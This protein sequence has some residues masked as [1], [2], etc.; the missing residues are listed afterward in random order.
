MF[1]VEE[2]DEE[3]KIY[4]QQTPTDNQRLPVNSSSSTIHSNKHRRRM[5]KS[6][7]YSRQY[8]PPP[9]FQKENDFYPQGV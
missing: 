2:P 1:V 6:P 3:P 7:S 4:E 9:R 8:H 5:G